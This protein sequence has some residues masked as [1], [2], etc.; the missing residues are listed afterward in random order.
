MSCVGEKCPPVLPFF[1]VSGLE[2]SNLRLTNEVSNPWEVVVENDVVDW[3]K[4]FIKVSF[5]KTYHAAVQNNWGSDLMALSCHWDGYEGSKIGVDTMYVVSMNDYNNDYAMNDTVNQ[6]V[7]VNIWTFSK[8]DY[9][10]FISISDYI[11]SNKSGISEMMFEVKFTEPP[12]DTLSDQKFKIVYT[13]TN[14]DSFE[15]ITEI[16]RLKS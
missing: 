8:A 1:E 14:G 12:F 9:D 15:T 5:E 13:L 4:Y 3:Q 7:L 16:V 11:E 6:M 2:S 10:E